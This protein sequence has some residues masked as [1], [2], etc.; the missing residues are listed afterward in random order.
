MTPV[1]FVTHTSGRRIEAMLGNNIVGVIMLIP[2]GRVA[3][4]YDMRLPMEGKYKLP[5]PASSIVLAKRN[6][7]IR[8]AEW[9]DAAGPIAA[10]ISSAIRVQAEE[11]R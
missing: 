9:F 3:A 11:E 7:L 8:I 4:Y 10:P 6:L 2:E 1:L 5:H